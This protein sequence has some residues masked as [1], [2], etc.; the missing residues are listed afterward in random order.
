M[1]AQWNGMGAISLLGCVD[2][3]GN[4]SLGTKM[5]KPGRPK[6]IHGR[7]RGR[8]SLCLNRGSRVTNIYA[9]LR[10]LDGGQGDI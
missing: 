5:L 2:G 10:V 8:R 6:D 4:S 9:A 3:K 7:G 1:Y